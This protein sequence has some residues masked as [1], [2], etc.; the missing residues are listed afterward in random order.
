M[1]RLTRSYRGAMASNID[2]TAVALASPVGSGALGS[3]M[4]FLSVMAC[5]KGFLGGR[6]LI[7]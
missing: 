6:S 3:G 7:S 5:W 4:L 1:I 2:R